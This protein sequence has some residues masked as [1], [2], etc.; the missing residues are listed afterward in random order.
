MLAFLEKADLKE[1]RKEFRVF[2]HV[3]RGDR[4]SVDNHH[5]VQELLL[6]SAGSEALI[7]IMLAPQIARLVL[8]F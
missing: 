6:R 1:Y 8:V 2:K 5:E 3:D 4:L 7:E